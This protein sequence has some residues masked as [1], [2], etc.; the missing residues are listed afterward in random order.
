MRTHLTRATLFVLMLSLVLTIPVFGAENSGLSAGISCNGFSLS[1]NF[2]ANR[3]NT[4]RGQESIVVQAVDGAGVIVYQLVDAVPLNWQITLDNAPFN[5]REVPTANPITVS[6]ISLAGNGQAQEVVY[7]ASSNCD[8]LKAG[9]A[10]N[11]A[12]ST[13]TV[14]V[15]SGS[16]NVSPSISVGGEVPV[17][18]TSAAAIE[19]LPYYV[20]INT[21][22]VNMRSGTGPQY[23]VVGVLTGG[24]RAAVVGRNK[25][26][27]WWLL[28]A[29]NVRGW[30]SNEF[31]A[32][33]GDLTDVPE[34]PN[35]GELQPITFVTSLEKTVFSEANNYDIN[36]VC[37][38]PAGEYRVIGK[39]SFNVFY[40]LEARCTDGRVVPAWIRGDEGAFRNPAVLALPVTD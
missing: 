39:D 18:T 16:T 32:V 22:A 36:Q 20:I 31:V 19:S 9:V 26:R 29:G 11:P 2:R 15:G 8:G 6:V 4:G 33:R 7:S 1:G 37:T 34:V 23:T 17:P 24:T 30:V 3:D 21:P 35:Q 38:I 28:E 27:S 13:A 5:W 14:A 10:A 40:Q 25:N 12:T